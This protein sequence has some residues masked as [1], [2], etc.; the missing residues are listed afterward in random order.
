M[1]GLC[2]DSETYDAKVQ[3][4]RNALGLITE[5]IVVGETMYQNEALILNAHQ[6]EYKENPMLGVGIND[7]VNDNDL[8]WWEHAIRVNLARDNMNVRTAKI[9]RKNGNITIEA[10]Y[11]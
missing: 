11:K 3:P 9:N 10:E 5:G 8:A 2:L 7:M 4:Q 6:G 1:K